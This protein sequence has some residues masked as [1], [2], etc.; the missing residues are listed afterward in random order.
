[1]EEAEGFALQRPRRQSFILSPDGRQLIYAAS[2][3]ETRR[4]YRRPMDRDQAM[5]IPGTEGGS[6]PCMAPDGRSVGFFVGGE[7]K[8][9][10]A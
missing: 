5:P 10:L 8:R 6:N 2:D 1:M 9:V 4:L 3:G 7:L